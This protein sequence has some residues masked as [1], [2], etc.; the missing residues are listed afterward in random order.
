MGKIINLKKLSVAPP[1]FWWRIHCDQAFWLNRL[2]FCKFLRI[3]VPK[4]NKNGLFPIHKNFEG[5]WKKYAGFQQKHR[6]IYI[7]SKKYHKNIFYS[8]NSLLCYTPKNCH[9]FHF[10]LI[11]R[12]KWHFSGYNKVES[13]TDKIC[14]YGILLVIYIKIYV[15]VEIP[16]I[17]FKNSSNLYNMEK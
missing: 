3:L 8:Q 13:F 10:F 1:N 16:D 15:F 4:M 12:I 9:F 7:L 5:F 17:F 11:F 14:F 2:S 6:F